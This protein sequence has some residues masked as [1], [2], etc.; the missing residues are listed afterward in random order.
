MA[1]KAHTMEW[2]TQH[3]KTEGGN[4]ATGAIH[5]SLFE[6]KK[7]PQAPNSNTANDAGTSLDRGPTPPKSKSCT[8]MGTIG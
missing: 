5:E 8:R 1:Q 6:T 7:G 4:H 2:N 3:T